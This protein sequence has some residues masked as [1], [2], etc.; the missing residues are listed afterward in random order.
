MIC[1]SY[2]I[3]DVSFYHLSDKSTLDSS[4]DEKGWYFKMTFSNGSYDI[5]GPFQSKEYAR[6]VAFGIPN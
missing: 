3:A 4:H 1:S 6:K 2:S 5:F